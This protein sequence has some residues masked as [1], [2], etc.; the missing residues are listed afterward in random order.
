M[1]LL[2][3]GSVL[4]SAVVA[5]ST[6]ALA[7]DESTESGKEEYL[8]RYKFRAGETIRWEVTH[9][10]IVR[11]TIAGTAQQTDTYSNS[12][13]VWNVDKVEDERAT[14]TYS[15]DRVEMRQKFDSRQDT[16]YNS[17]TDA[18]PPPGYADV[19]KS[20]KVPLGRVTLDARGTTID[21]QELVSQQAAP[22]GE[23][24]LPLP[25]KAVAVGEQWSIPAD[26]DV[27]LQSGET[28]KV[29]ARQQFTLEEVTDGVAVI[30]VETQVLSPIRDQPEIEAQILQSKSN[31]HL[32]FDIAAGRLIS[33]ENEV[34]ER[35]NGFA[36]NASF[37]HYITRITETLLPPETKTASKP[38]TA[39]SG[40]GGK[41]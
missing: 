25:E 40:K 22:S 32:R 18:V 15:V 23:V 27:K 33:Q 16:H 9:E 34:N 35:V 12:V 29:K 21:R 37:L 1:K 39:K 28:K 14:V 31:G 6:V 26:I 38:G 30:R 2:A 3:I 11:S 19:A 10:A 7:A 4:L 41:K 13:K 8:L 5:S 20:I 36:G 17:D 24:T